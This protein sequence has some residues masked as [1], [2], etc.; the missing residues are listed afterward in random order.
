MVLVLSV[1]AGASTVRDVAAAIGKAEGFGKPH[2]IPTRYHNVGDLKAAPGQKWPGQ[3]GVGKGRHVIFKSDAAGWA[4]LEGQILRIIEGRS[5]VYRSDTTIHQ[6]AKRYAE[7]WRVWERNVATNLGVTPDTELRE[8][9]YGRSERVAEVD[10]GS[11][12]QIAP[13]EVGQGTARAGCP[14][15]Y[16]ADRAG[17]LPV[18]EAGA[19]TGKPALVGGMEDS[20][21]QMVVA[22]KEIPGSRT[23]ITDSTSYFP[24]TI[25]MTSGRTHRPAKTIHSWWSTLLHRHRGKPSGVKN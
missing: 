12:Y 7:N 17:E 6:M 9:I 8:I 16:D 14:C 11:W 19:A 20:L 18:L 22:A 23:W 1:A 15:I 5:H 13:P 2:A 3:I 25:V 24:L 21:Q 4:A 10:A